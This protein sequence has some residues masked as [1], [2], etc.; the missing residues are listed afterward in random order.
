MAHL[1]FLTWS[2]SSELLLLTVMAYDWY[3]AIC[4]PLHYSTMMSRA[5]CSML[6]TG[7]WVLCAFNS[8]IHTGL[9][10]HLNFC[11]P[12]VIT[13]FFC[14]AP[15]LLLLSCSSTYVNSVMIVLADAFYGILNF[16]MTLVSYG[17]IISSILNEDF[18][19]ETE[20]LLHLLLPPHCGV[21]VLHCCLLC[22]HKSCLQLQC[23]EEQ[24]GW[25]AIHYVE[26]YPQPSHLYFEKQGGQSSSC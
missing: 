10:L 1:Y 25:C 19:G 13:H 26:S 5:F 24:G 22:L 8:A 20:S 21:H 16:L 18:R 11:G 9:M 17:F 4:H 6:A 14:E 12:N 15:P 23:R 3:A 2:A 7:V